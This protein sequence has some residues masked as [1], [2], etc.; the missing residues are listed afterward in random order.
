MTPIEFIL[1]ALHAAH[2]NAHD[3][4]MRGEWASHENMPI[5]A[6]QY[7]I[8]TIV[9]DICTGDA[10]GVPE[11]GYLHVQYDDNDTAFWFTKAELRPVLTEAL[12][13]FSQSN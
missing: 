1:N 8:S 7:A 9:D 3:M 10:S 2:D 11:C 13:A 5:S 6:S 12:V 4:G